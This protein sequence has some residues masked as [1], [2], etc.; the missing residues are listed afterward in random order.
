MR[1]LKRKHQCNKR[2]SRYKTG[3]VETLDFYSV[4]CKLGTL[5]IDFLKPHSREN[6]L[7]FPLKR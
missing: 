2:E 5:Q 3:H 6:S 1:R 7:N 4:F